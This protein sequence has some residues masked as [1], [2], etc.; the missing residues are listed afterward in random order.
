MSKFIK[1]L[2][3]FFSFNS[4]IT[5]GLDSYIAKKNPTS[6]ADVERLTRQYLENDRFCGG[7]L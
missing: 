6:I 2:T 4:S 7:L 1:E 3:Q 5:S